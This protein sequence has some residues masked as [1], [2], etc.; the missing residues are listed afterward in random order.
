MTY[1]LPSSLTAPEPLP[2]W[3]WENGRPTEQSFRDYGGWIFRNRP[4][5]VEISEIASLNEAQRGFAIICQL[6]RELEAARGALAVVTLPGPSH[7]AP[8]RQ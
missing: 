4:D 2:A 8:E 3:R 5:L 1:E 7:P 6:L